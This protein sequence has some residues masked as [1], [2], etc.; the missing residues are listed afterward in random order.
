MTGVNDGG[1]EYNPTGRMTLVRRVGLNGR[2]MGYDHSEASLESTGTQQPH[3]RPRPP[4]NEGF[5][6]SNP[7]VTRGRISLL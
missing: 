1:R 5:S 2:G 4:G 6:W 3:Q 7:G